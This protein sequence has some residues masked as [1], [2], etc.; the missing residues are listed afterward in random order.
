ML[1]TLNS[2]MYT[3]NY[4]IWYV[5]NK[6]SIEWHRFEAPLFNLIPSEEVICDSLVSY[7]I[8]RMTCSFISGI[9]VINDAN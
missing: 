2:L 9:F 7:S 4:T 6:F 1:F 3:I 8:G 5:V